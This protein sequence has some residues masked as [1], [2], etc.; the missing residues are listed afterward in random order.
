MS[1]AKQVREIDVRVVVEVD[2]YGDDAV[3]PHDLC[4]H[5]LAVNSDSIVSAVPVGAG[6]LRDATEDEIESM[7]WTSPDDEEPEED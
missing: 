6:R 3:G 1:K 7:C 4:D 2:E 5:V